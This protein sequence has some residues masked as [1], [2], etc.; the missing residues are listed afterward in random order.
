[1]C[2]DLTGISM[3]QAHDHLA[4]QKDYTTP[5]SE[6]KCW[7]ATCTALIPLALGYEQ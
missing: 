2:H 1:M 5:E 6:R 4:E 7:F 3:F